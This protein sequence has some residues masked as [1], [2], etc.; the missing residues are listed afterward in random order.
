MDGRVEDGFVLSEQLQHPLVVGVV[1]DDDVKLG[2]AKLDED[3]VEGGGSQ[4]G[5]LPAADL[6]QV[7]VHELGSNDLYIKCQQCNS[8]GQKI[9]NKS[10]SITL[11]K[12]ICLDLL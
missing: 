11:A 9:L 3:L 8:L 5:D 6:H 4:L 12:L 7:L 1:R 2:P 10:L